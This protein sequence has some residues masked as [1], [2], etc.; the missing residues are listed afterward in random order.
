MSK[1]IIK[2]NFYLSK[3]IGIEAIT[4]K[5]I[6]NRLVKNCYDP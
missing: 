5:L 2:I 4:I 6:F 3:P 1:Y